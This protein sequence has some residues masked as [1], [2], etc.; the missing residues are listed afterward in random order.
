MLGVVAHIDAKTRR[1]VVAEGAGGSGVEALAVDGK[2]F[3]WS[4]DAIIIV[5]E[6]HG[7][8]VG[9]DEGDVAVGNDFAG[10]ADVGAD[11]VGASGEVYL[12]VAGVL[13]AVQRDGTGLVGGAVGLH[14]GD[15]V[16]L[17]VAAEGCAD[18]GILVAYGEG[19][20]ADGSSGGVVSQGVVFRGFA[21]VIAE[22]QL[23]AG[24]PVVLGRVVAVAVA[25]EADVSGHL[26]LDGDVGI[27]AIDEVGAAD[28]GDGGVGPYI[29][30][31]VALVAAVVVAVGGG[32][33]VAA[34]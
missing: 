14:V 23:C 18:G 34:K 5:C 4:I 22:G 11:V 24:A 15:G 6:V 17:S 28:A 25:G 9:E 32:A 13:M 21:K 12:V 30:D 20:A 16:G 3:D 27:G 33:S 2:V 1:A 29:A 31:G 7:A 8:T 10:I 26:G 19:R